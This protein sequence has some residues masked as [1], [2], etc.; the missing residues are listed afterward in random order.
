MTEQ[1]RLIQSPERYSPRPREAYGQ[2]LHGFAFGP[3]ASPLLDTVQAWNLAY[4]S[5]DFEAN[6]DHPD[7]Q[8]S[9]LVRRSTQVR[10]HDGTLGLADELKDLSGSW[11]LLPAPRF[12]Y[13]VQNFKFLSEIPLYQAY[14]QAW[15]DTIQARG[16]LCQASF[17]PPEPLDYDA[18]ITASGSKTAD[19]LFN[20]LRQA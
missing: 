7:V 8:F 16:R 10:L 1:N 6:P 11:L 5:Y 12:V 4:L 20:R 17:G 13:L 19:G 15:L 2:I 3:S 14:G 18:E 9:T